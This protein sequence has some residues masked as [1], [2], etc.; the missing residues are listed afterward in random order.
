MTDVILGYL[1]PAL[2][3]YALPGHP[4]RPRIDAAAAA[5]DN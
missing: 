3:P 1:R 4:L 2:Q 5:A